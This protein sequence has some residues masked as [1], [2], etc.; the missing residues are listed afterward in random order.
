MISVLKSGNQELIRTYTDHGIW[1]VIECLQNHL[2]I[3]FWPLYTCL[4]AMPYV[5]SKLNA[6]FGSVGCLDDATLLR[7]PRHSDSL[8]VP[9]KRFVAIA[10]N[11]FP[12]RDHQPFQFSPRIES[13]SEY[14]TVETDSLSITPQAQ[15]IVPFPSLPTSCSRLVE[16]MTLA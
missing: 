9:R 11:H 13:P 8:K 14:I 12:T 5:K 3:G 7:R 2:H 6:Q 15:G 10:I 1:V 16:T 4:L